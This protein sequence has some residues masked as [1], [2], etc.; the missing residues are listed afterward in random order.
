MFFAGLKYNTLVNYTFQLKNRYNTKWIPENPW[1]LFTP[2]KF[3]NVGFIIHKPKRTALEAKKYAISAR[4]GT[5]SSKESIHVCDTFFLKG[6]DDNSFDK[7][8]TIE[9]DISG[10]FLPDSKYK[11]PQIILIEGA[12]GIGKTMLMEEIKYLWANEKIL[13]DKEVLLLLP[14]CDPK[15]NEIKYIEDL[16]YYS[17]KSRE[18]AKM[19]A[20]HFISNSGQGLVMLLDGLDENPQ[21]MRMQSGAF[22]YDILIEQKI[23]IEACIVITSRPHATTELQQFV[24]YRV[25]IIGFTD[26]RRQEFVQHNFKENAEVIADYLQKHE[27]IDTLCYIPLNMSIIVSLFKE[28]IR[29]E[30]LPTTQTELILQATRITVFHNLEKLGM[31]KNKI[32]LENLPE[33]YDKILY[34][35]SELAYNALVENRVT[36]T[37]DEIMKACPIPT[38]GD[39]TIE[40]AIINGLGLLQTARFFTDADGDTQVLSNFA[41]Y[42]VQELLAA[43]YIAFRHRYHFQKLPLMCSIQKGIQKC[44][45][46]SFQLQ[47]LNDKFWEGNLMNMWSFY[48]GLTGGE[49]FAFK[50]FLSEKMLCSYM[51]CKRLYSHQKT[52]S[53][54]ITER[55]N[56]AQCIISKNILENKI[57]ILFLYF[58]LQEASGNKIIEHLNIVVSESRL[59][60][61][62][63]SL[64]LKDIRLLGFILSR[65]Y[66]TKQ[67]KLVDI[68][69]CQ[70]DDENF[71]VLHELLTR[72]DGRPKPEI[73]ALSLSGNELKLSSDVIVHLVHC[74]KVVH[75]N[76]SNNLLIDVVPFKQCGDFLE[77]LDISNNKLGNENALEFFNVLK[78]LRKLKV[79]KLSHNNINDDQH[80]IDAIGLALCSCSS[81]QELRLDGNSTKFEDKAMLFFQ[82]ISEIKNSK[83][84]IHYYRLTNK[85]H[86]FLKIL[87]Y[88]DQLDYQAE[89]CVLKNKIIQS[90]VV[91]V[92]Y[93]G[94]KTEDGYNLGQHLHL[95]VNL[96]ILNIANNNICDEATKSLA[97]GMLL[98]P[99]LEE[100]KYDEN[101]FSQDSTTIFEVINQLRQ[102]SN[103][104]VL[105]YASSKVKA[106]VF[107]LNCIND[108]EE[109]LQSSDIV[110]TISHI[111]ELNLSH[112]EPTTLDYKLI[113]EDLN[114]LCAVLIW[115][116][117]LKVLDVRNNNITD[118]ITESMVKVMLQ[119]NALNSLKLCGNPISGHTFY[120]AIFETI[121]NVREKQMQS[122]I[123]DQKDPSSCMKCQ[124]I[125]YIMDCL[126]Q[127]EN[128]ECFNLF[129]N[130]TTVDT[131]SE[132]NYGVKL[133]EYLKFLPFLTN[134]KVNNV[135]YITDCG[136]NQLSKYLSH[137]RTLTTL[138]LS[139]CNLC[140][141]EVESGPSNNFP[142][143]TLKFN[144]CNITDQVLFKLSLNILKFSNLDQLELEGNCFGD[145]GI[146]SMYNV[147]MSCENDQLKTTITLLNL[148]NNQLT[149]HSATEIFEIVQLCMVKYLNISNNCFGCI[150]PYF[151]QNSI[152]TLEVLNISSN[153]LKANAVCLGQCLHLLVN[154]RILDI[155]KNYVS[156]EATESLATGMLLTPSLEFNY[157]EN[158]F[159]KDSTMI[160]EMIH[161]LHNTSNETVFKCAPSEVK[162]LIFILNCINDNE[163]K[164][165]SSDI[166]STISHIT[167]LNLSHNEST[168][169][170]YKLTNEDLNELCAVLRWFKQLKVLDL[171]NNEI[172]DVCEEVIV[173][174]MLQYYT[175]NCIKLSGNPIFNNELSKA[176]FDTIINVREMRTQS[177]ICCQKSSHLE[178]QAVICIMDYLKQFKNS[179]CCKLFNGITILDV[180][181]KLSHT[182]KVLENL[183]FLPYLSSLKINNV[184]DCDMNQLCNYLS[185]NKTLTTLDLSFCNL[186]NLE[187]AEGASIKFSLQTLKLN[188]SNITDLVLFNLSLNVLKFTNLDQL[189]LEGNHF[190]DKGISSMYSALMSC[191]NDQLS[192]TITSLNLA[193]N[194]LTSSS[195]FKIIGIVQNYKVK[196]LD[197]SQN[198][199]TFLPCFEKHTDTA[200]EELNFF[201]NNLKVDKNFFYMLQ[202]CTQLELLDLEDN[203]ITNDTFKYLTTG[204]LF[205][206]KLKVTNLRLNGNPCMDNPKNGLYLKIIEKLHCESDHQCFKCHP[207]EFE[208]FLTILELVDGCNNK[209]N[210]TSKIV[211]CIKTLDISYSEIFSTL[212]QKIKVE[213]CDIIKFC[214]YLKFFESLESINLFGNNITEEG[215]KPLATAIL[216]NSNVIEI[217]LEGNPMYK[218][219]KHTKLFDT[220]TKMRT[221][222]NSYC[223]KDQPEMLEAFVDILKY[224]NDFDDKTCDITKNIEHLDI[225]QFLPHHSSRNLTNTSSIEEVDNPEE[226]TT[227]L[228]QHLKLF[229]RLKTLNLNQ[230]YVT[231]VALEELSTFLRNNDT[232][233]ELDL[234]SN[235]ILAEGALVVLKSLDKN[236]TLKK[237][238]L[239]TNNISGEKKCKEIALIICSLR[240]NI[241]VD[242]LIGN[243]FTEE[244]KTILDTVTLYR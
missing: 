71:Q 88:C 76:L 186:S 187:I 137:N 60:I 197:I 72:K 12:P 203:G 23:F 33:P 99:N 230:A 5:F 64:N 16:F 184:A 142:L 161:Q 132:S 94:L 189:E 149:E 120:M 63:Q 145:K 78:A 90:N 202:N 171:G 228:I 127:L 92:S 82:V 141:L 35:V 42:S 111:T 3:V 57:K 208:I 236:I 209:S 150:F 243:K 143:R 193:D 225:S 146:S 217:Q 133:L 140:N 119:I 86:A 131:S 157:D 219:K 164:L 17:C 83:S 51:L 54:E 56:P 101:L 104:T 113:S 31:Y 48:I 62:K 194:Q 214:K 229:H 155:S 93:N 190:G 124:C 77:T 65:P 134:L 211:S 151:E 199:L 232:L 91:N 28:N 185:S 122:I 191:E 41:H 11:C 8:V 37:S 179:L 24:S 109:K 36:F 58:L 114:E 181:S 220:I 218:I 144:H 242:V 135:E 174:T 49:D 103:K 162:A 75:L 201:H 221:C 10:M 1:P 188:H 87:G 196:H 136:I 121:K 183:I 244:S 147:L 206:C 204:F 98:T 241:Q 29:L 39:Q 192:T 166:V 34:Y 85:I 47:S 18:D 95:L 224:V 128:S 213:S 61:S 53:S 97:T 66:L 7:Y 89:S 15:I 237:L 43:W 152:T 170:D 80:V 207:A 168:T 212:N 176:V 44:V 21:A 205:T 26:E 30:T 52:T 235:H 153:G 234:S 96:K 200:L 239:S 240:H 14:L 6:C 159:S 100:F 195:A 116:K 160:F 70:I 105:K 4:S 13:T 169:L 180:D 123:Y 226:I 40:R 19:Y 112:S 22:F 154:L 163:E 68:S 102:T 167:V 108:N 110:S 50:H 238:N 130:I 32:N 118:E 126:N 129:E 9:E 223:F 231:L 106:L 25:E 27:I 138:D 139:S 20:K 178:C 73:K 115:F 177:I 175:L 2:E 45:Q 198:Q 79:L 233:L 125:I 173:K 227:C 46:F 165:Q 210:D 107:I 216:K 81:L 59:D 55:V 222:G 215:K 117:Q 158:F 67:W 156:D 84:N 69:N 182:N 74:Q 148:A 172:T 38:N